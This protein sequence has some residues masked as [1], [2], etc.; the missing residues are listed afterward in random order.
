MIKGLFFLFACCG[1]IGAQFYNL[2]TTA[3]GSVLA[4]SS[5]LTMRGYSQYGWA[6]LFRIDGAGLSLWEQRQR[7]APSPDDPGMTN[8]YRMEG[9]EFSADGSVRALITGRDCYYPGSSCLTRAKSH[10]EFRGIPERADL[11]ITGDARI[12]PNGRYATACC[13]GSMVSPALVSDLQTAETKTYWEIAA[14][15]LGRP[16][17]S[18]D[19]TAVFATRDQSVFLATLSG[20]QTLPTLALTQTAAID[21]NA[22]TVVYQGSSPEGPVIARIDLPARV[23]KTIVAG[24]DLVLVG[25][26]NDGATVAFTSAALASGEGAGATQLFIVG[27][28]GNGFRQVT[29]DPAGVTE[30]VLAGYGQ[31][32]YAV[33]AAGRLLKID[34]L[35][36]DV[37]QLAGRTLTILPYSSFWQPGV[38]GSAF[39][40]RG[41]GLADAPAAA[42]PPLPYSLGRLTLLLDGAPLPL[43]S[44]APSQVCFQIPWET[45]GGER[46]LFA[47]AE[48]DPT[49]EGGNTATLYVSGSPQIGFIDTGGAQPLAVHQDFSGPITPESPAH[50]GEYV[51]FYMTGL[52]PV[53]PPV[54]TGGPGPVF[55]LSWTTAPLQCT[56]AGVTADADV[57][58]AGL[59]PGLAGYY[60]VSVRV[61]EGVETSNG[62]TSILCGM[63][64]T[65][66]FGFLPVALP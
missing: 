60:Q 45:S 47:E 51:Q 23:E 35:S 41:S 39:C 58:F 44:V 37:S 48:S 6:K 18:D 38:A 9:A 61:P 53:A 56:F 19:G 12:S 43:Q 46:L 64:G 20:V 57:P 11:A 17:I 5:S 1:P 27:A 22:T 52:G 8:Y 2:A 15:K 63:P 40:A 32:A 30:A 10:S 62:F 66:A 14:T 13:D 29:H 31:I 26:S 24:T 59:A 34:V 54:P 25:T 42:A 33:T 4:F 49:F 7:V 36:G 16:A 21:Q 50:P 3:D 65:S 28:D 55:P